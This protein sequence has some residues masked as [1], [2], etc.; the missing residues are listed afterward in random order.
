[1]EPDVAL[2]VEAHEME[3]GGVEVADVVAVDRR[4]GHAS[5]RSFPTLH[6]EICSPTSITRSAGTW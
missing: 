4:P 3:D 6:S 2:V 5:L 1:M